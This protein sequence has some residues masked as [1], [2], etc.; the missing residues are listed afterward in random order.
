V[1][2][3][4]LT[5]PDRYG[6]PWY[7]TEN[8]GEKIPNSRLLLTLALLLLVVWPTPSAQA[9]KK[10]IE[11]GV[12]NPDTLWMRD[13]IAEMEQATFDGC[14]CILTSN[15][16]RIPPLDIG[17]FSYFQWSDRQ[18]TYGEMQ[19]G[20]DAIANTN[21]NKFTDVFIR[22]D[23][24]RPGTVDWFD[25]ATF[26]IIANNMTLAG[27]AAF[28]GGIKGL[29]FDPE[30]Y[31]FPGMWTYADQPHFATKTFAEYVAKVRQR[32]AQIMQAWQGEYPNI[33][34][35]MLRSYVTAFG[36]GSSSPFYAPFTDDPAKL[37][38]IEYYGLLPAFIDGMLAVVG[39]GVT[40][41]DSGHGVLESSWMTEEDFALMRQWFSTDVLGLV[42]PDVRTKYSEHFTLTTNT[43]L[44]PLWRTGGWSDTDFSINDW[45]PEEVTMSITNGLNESDEYHWLYTEHMFYWGSGKH[46]PQEYLDAIAEAYNNSFNIIGDLT[47]DFIVD[48]N[49]LMLFA[50]DWLKCTFPGLPGCQNVPGGGGGPVGS[51]TVPNFSFEDHTPPPADGS[52][53][54]FA[55][56]GQPGRRSPGQPGWESTGGVSVWNTTSPSFHST[57]LPHGTHVMDMETLDFTSIK[58][59]L[60]MLADLK[61]GL[62]YT[63]SVDISGGPL[64][65]WGTIGEAQVQVYAIDGMTPTT[66]DKVIDGPVVTPPV[67]WTTLEYSFIATAAHV[68]MDLLI[69]LADSDN[70]P[71]GYVHWD[72]L[73]VDEDG[74]CGGWGYLAADFNLDCFVN[75]K[76][77][78]VIMANGMGQ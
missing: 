55:Q 23:A 28:E 45:Q 33:T 64:S 51:L 22:I 60:F 38:F 17:D 7:I 29:F 27:R 47:G 49:D 14:V 11:M 10:L 69:E 18:F 50:T 74:T 52:S 13:N 30:P 24:G 8:K 54:P 72:N 76:D 70:S 1:E 63:V 31:Y 56:V 2:I 42:S 59:A 20:M 48:A 26:I 41:A 4:C 46:P 3:I 9:K 37:E 5:S 53:T 39:P 35:F 71:T 32:G 66:F 6:I 19:A 34:I 58:A 68:G 44:D 43:Y 12:D 15:I 73:R 21:F 75:L 57:P 62:E 16:G 78:A 67:E 25:D 77:A 61:E 40:F 36:L 65:F